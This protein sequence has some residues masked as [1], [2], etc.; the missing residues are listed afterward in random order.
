IIGLK[1]SCV[2]TK[3]WSSKAHVESAK[4]GVLSGGGRHFALFNLELFGLFN[5]KIHRVGESLCDHFAADRNLAWHE[6]L[7]IAIDVDGRRLVAHIHKANR[8]TVEF[9]AVT[10]GDRPCDA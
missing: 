10:E 1:F 5:G 3:G 8:L 2:A 6:E 9:L 7:A 4:P